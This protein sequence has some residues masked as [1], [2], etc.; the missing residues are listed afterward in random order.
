M[1]LVDGKR[2]R[3]STTPT[4]P[5]ST[6]KE[7]FLSQSPIYFPTYPRPRGKKGERLHRQPKE[8]FSRVPLVTSSPIANIFCDS[9]ETFEAG[10]GPHAEEILADIPN[11]TDLSP[12]IQISDVDVA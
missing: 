8:R 9:V 4:T 5:R 11:Y 6:F 1:T 12:V 3:H 10:F 7:T 2:G